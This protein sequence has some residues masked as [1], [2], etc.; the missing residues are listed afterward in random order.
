MTACLLIKVKT[1]PQEMH[2]IIT[3]QN[4][5]FPF[6]KQQIPELTGCTCK[7]QATFVSCSYLLLTCIRWQVELIPSVIRKYAGSLSRCS[8]PCERRW[9]IH[10]LSRSTLMG[11]DTD[12]IWYWW[13]WYWYSWHKWSNFQ[14]TGA[15]YGTSSYCAFKKVNHH[16]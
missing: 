11:Y 6:S 16:Y 13:Y 10:R 3:N 4:N 9:G 7:R 5:P 8:L 2:V 1:L 12:R 14:N 15:A